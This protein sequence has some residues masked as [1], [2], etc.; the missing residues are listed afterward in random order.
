MQGIYTVFITNVA[1]QLVASCE[2]NM[3][4]RSCLLPEVPGGR[5]DH[6]AHMPNDCL[7]I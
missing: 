1:D 2:L 7:L 3:H 4:T 5:R 6:D